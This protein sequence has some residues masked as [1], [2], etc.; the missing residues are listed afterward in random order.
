MAMN[1][2]I[3]LKK[4]GKTFSPYKVARDMCHSEFREEADAMQRG[5]KED[6]L[7]EQGLL[8][9]DEANKLT[10]DQLLNSVVTQYTKQRGGSCHRE[11]FFEQCRLYAPNNDTSDCQLR[12]TKSSLTVR[13]LQRWV[14]LTPYLE[15]GSEVFYTSHES[16]SPYYATRPLH[17]VDGKGKR[18][19]VEFLLSERWKPKGT[20]QKLN[21]TERRSLLL[22]MSKFK[23]KYRQKFIVEWSNGTFKAPSSSR[24]VPFLQ[25]VTLEELKPQNVNALLSTV[26]LE[27]LNQLTES[28]S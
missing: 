12:D 3:V 14:Y 28:S 1:K 16:G 2:R 17:V 8:T 23:D 19:V 18:S 24:S 15:S 22:F 21:A 20:N 13:A 4:D 5:Q 25:L 10:D 7:V 11:K 27:R 6:L 26:T 9:K